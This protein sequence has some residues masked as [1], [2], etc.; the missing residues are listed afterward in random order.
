VGA[1]VCKSGLKTGF[2][3]GRITALDVTA[4]YGANIIYGLTQHNACVEPGDSGGSNISGGAYAL[5]VT[6]GASLVDRKY[7]LSRYGQRNV[8]WYQPIGEALSRNGLRL[9]T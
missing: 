9:L 1:T 4:S 3:C 5:G 8:S 6:S 7:C 2:T